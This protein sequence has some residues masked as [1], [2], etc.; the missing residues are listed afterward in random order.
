MTNFK[1]ISQIKKDKAKKTAIETDL[2][3]QYKNA[4]ST[5]FKTVSFEI[6]SFGNKTGMYYSD[7]ITNFSNSLTKEL[8]SNKELNT[9]K[10]IEIF[11]R[12][13]IEL[14]KDIVQFFIAIDNY[15]SQNNKVVEDIFISKTNINNGFQNLALV[16]LKRKQNS[17]FAMKEYCLNVIEKSSYF[18]YNS[19]FISIE[20]CPLKYDYDN[21]MY[22]LEHSYCTEV[23]INPFLNSNKTPD[24]WYA[25]LYWFELMSNGE[26]PPKKIGGNFNKS[27]IKEIGREKCKSSGEYFYK[28]FKDIDISNQKNLKAQFGENWKEEVKKLSNNNTKIS[29]Y[30]EE[31][32]KI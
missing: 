3:N 16:N 6:D 11:N 19:L 10:E 21:L 30:I 5:S 1:G 4:I 32:Y 26:Q 8:Q 15:D 24:K 14:L 31:N 20:K 18:L 9:L 17:S 28:S 29:K 7:Y 27:K 25:L 12:T 2:V 23:D 22:K 13:T